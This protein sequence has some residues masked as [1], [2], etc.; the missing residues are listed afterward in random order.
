[1]FSI[2][3]SMSERTVASMGASGR[4]RPSRVCTRAHSVIDETSHTPSFMTRSTGKIGSTAVETPLSSAASNRARAVV[5]GR[6]PC[7]AGGVTSVRPRAITTVARG[8]SRMRPSL[9]VKITSSAPCSAAYRAAA[10]FT[11]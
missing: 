1:M 11:A 2:P 5:P 6:M 8:A 4:A 3:A 9:E 10:M 7:S